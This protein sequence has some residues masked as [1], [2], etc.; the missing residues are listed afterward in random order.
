MKNHN[1]GGRAARLCCAGWET[2]VSRTS[3][4]IARPPSFRIVRHQRGSY[5]VTKSGRIRKY[6]T[7]L[8]GV[9]HRARRHTWQRHTLGRMQLTFPTNRWIHHAPFAFREQTKLTTHAPSRLFRDTRDLRQYG[10]EGVHGYQ[11]SPS[12]PLRNRTS[13]KKAFIAPNVMN[14]H[15]CSNPTQ[16]S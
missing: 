5:V 15:F 7:P 12:H 1:G 8:E 6:T 14:P 9:I 13:S 2:S 16:A 3:G 10:H 11:H 4:Q